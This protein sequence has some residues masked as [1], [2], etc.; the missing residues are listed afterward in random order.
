MSVNLPEGSFPLTQNV[1]FFTLDYENYLLK[2]KIFADQT[3]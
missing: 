2:L 3:S 1:F